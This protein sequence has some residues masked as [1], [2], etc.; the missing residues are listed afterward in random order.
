MEYD[1]DWRRKD[2]N[3]EKGQRYVSLGRHD[4]ELIMKVML[5]MI[6]NGQQSQETCLMD[7]REDISKL[8]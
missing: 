7:I 4:T 6:V 8:T 5:S 3:K 2:D 1:G